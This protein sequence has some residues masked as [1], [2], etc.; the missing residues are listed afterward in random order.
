M[1]KPANKCSKR[2]QPFTVTKLYCT[3]MFI[4]FQVMLLL[5]L[6]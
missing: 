3:R 1:I 6:E 2:L 5:D 4:Y